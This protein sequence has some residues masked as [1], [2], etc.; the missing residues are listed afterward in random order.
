MPSAP[1][2]A[3]TSVGAP[4]PAVFNGA[5]PNDASDVQMTPDSNMGV[6]QPGVVPPIDHAQL[7]FDAYTSQRDAQ[8]LRDSCP[9][10]LAAPATQM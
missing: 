7:V 9:P 6:V 1:A 4:T 2:V 5:P 8:A 10:P 3:A